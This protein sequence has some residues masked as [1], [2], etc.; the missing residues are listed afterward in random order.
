MGYRLPCITRR[1]IYCVARAERGDCEQAVTG[2]VGG[3]PR[4]TGPSQYAH[5]REHWLRAFS[6]DVWRI[7][8]RR[9]FHFSITQ[10]C[11]W[12]FLF[13]VRILAK[14]RLNTCAF[15]VTVHSA[16][17][18]LLE[19]P[20]AEYHFHAGLRAFKSLGSRD[21]IPPLRTVRSLHTRRQS[22]FQAR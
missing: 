9:H 2:C 22:P 21:G 12:E 13:S 3:L 4:A 11:R 17:S 8:L 10:S 16:C 14:R 1:G 19:S 20:R 15:T 7:I 5:R 6:D 18:L